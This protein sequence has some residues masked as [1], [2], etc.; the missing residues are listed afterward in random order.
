MPGHDRTRTRLSGFLILQVMSWFHHIRIKK[1][2]ALLQLTRE[3]NIAPPFD[4]QLSWS[5]GAFPH[6]RRQ[7]VEKLK[8][9]AG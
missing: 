2:Y 8:R 4:S 5:F 3:T 1:F 9:S 6:S 7:R